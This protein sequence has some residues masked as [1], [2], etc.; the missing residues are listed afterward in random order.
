MNGARQIGGV[1]IKLLQQ[2]REKFV[3]VEFVEVFPVEI[4]AI[5]DAAAAQVEK[6]RGHLRRLGVP[7]EHVGV[8]ARGGGDFLALLDLLD[9]A[10][11]VAIAGG[12]FVALRFGGLRHALAQAGDQ[13][14]AAAFEKRARV[15]RGFG[16]AFVGG[17]SGDAGPQAAMNVVLQAGARMSARE[18]HGAGGHAKMLVDEV[19]D[20][21][22]QAVRENTGRNRASRPCAGGA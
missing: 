12:L 1:E 4:A 19:H 15:A 3:G 11:Q 18:V 21:V 7:R 8:V 10:E 14:V 22:R 13:I 17:E 9:G 5:H 20:A 6:I 16:V 2:R